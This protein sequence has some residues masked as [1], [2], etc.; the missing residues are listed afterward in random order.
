MRPGSRGAGPGL[1]LRVAEAEGLRGEGDGAG[2]EAGV[3]KGAHLLDIDL[4]V[5]LTA[6]EH[7]LDAGDRRARRSEA[8]RRSKVRRD[9]GHLGN[10][11]LLQEG[12]GG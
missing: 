10:L 7:V 12:K 3:Q 5:L 4:R 8:R 2:M 9:G 6:H 11:G 1:V